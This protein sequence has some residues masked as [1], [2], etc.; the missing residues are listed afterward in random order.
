MKSKPCERKARKNISASVR[1]Q[2]ARHSNF[3]CS[4]CGA[5]PIVFHHIEN[6]SERY[7]HNDKYLIPICDKC[8]RGIHGEGGCMFSKTELY[9]FKK[10]PKSPLILRDK[11]PLDRK[12]SYSFFI[13]SN[14]IDCSN[15]SVGFK[16]FGN[17]NLIS[18][19]KSEGILKLNI[20]VETQGTKELYLIKD[21]ELLIDT[22]DM[23]N[24]K[25]SRN[26]LTIWRSFGSQKYKFI[27]L[28]IE[29]ELI[30]IRHM[31]TVF[32]QKPFRIYKLKQPHPRQVE[33]LRNV[34]QMFEDRYIE[35]AKAIDLTPNTGRIIQGID[36]DAVLKQVNKDLVKSR[37][38]SM[39]MF[40]I[41][42][43]FNKWSWLYYSW[44]LDKILSNSKIFGQHKKDVGT[45]SD[46]FDIE[47]KKIENYAAQIRK[48]YRQYFKSLE[49]VVVEFGGIS[50]LD[51]IQIPTLKEFDG[52]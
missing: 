41:S 19:D 21:N 26:A 47:I 40:E 12:Q 20:L 37:M 43:I 36:L 38:E 5:I 7:S 42:K 49:D 27:D 24:M 44:V 1:R 35:A 4:I 18:F 2:L 48:R 16:V 29:P 15:T 52:N 23:W 22:H 34:V 14:F 6:W 33:K 46:N 25:Y 11:L 28:I 13:G 51:N 50:M 9:E 17:R 31:N 8:H 39:L 45:L 30:I 32:D 10:R 3:A